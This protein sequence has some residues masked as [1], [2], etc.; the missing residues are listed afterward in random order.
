MHYLIS[1]VHNDIARLRE[2]LRQ[3]SFSEGDR[4]F[5][6]G[7]LFDRSSH[8]P[9]PVGVYF[10]ILGLGN[11]CTVLRGNHDEW[12]AQYILDYYCTPERKRKTLVPYPYNSF[13]LLRKRLPPVDMLELA[14]WILSKP[15]CIEITVA[16]TNYLLAHDIASLC[17]GA[18]S[19]KQKFQA[20]G[21]DGYISIFGHDSTQDQRIW[22][23]RRGN[24]YCIDC[25]CG[26]RSG[27]LG[28]LCLETRQEFY[29]S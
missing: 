19:D 26:Y 7:D 5:I 21:V 27:Q 1:D 3:I 6:L 17:S 14:N 23:N 11:R 28:C 29:A 13:D 8:A 9:D 12:L 18:A 15:N 24:V 20:S 4:L 22:K 16:G 2:I 25:G 10:T